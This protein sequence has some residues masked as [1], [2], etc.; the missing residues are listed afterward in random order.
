MVA[1]LKQAA[2]SPAQWLWMERLLHRHGMSPRI[3]WQAPPPDARTSTSDRHATGHDQ[4]D[5]PRARRA[6]G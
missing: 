5:V 6:P 1:V 4:A 3:L 2:T